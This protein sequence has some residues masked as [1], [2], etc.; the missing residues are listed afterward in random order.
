MVG[1]T[2]QIGQGLV[3]ALGI[4]TLKARF[5]RGIGAHTKEYCIVFFEQFSK[6][7]VFTDSNPEFELNTHAF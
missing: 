2:N 6:W 4:F 7:D 3:Y 5:H 1:I